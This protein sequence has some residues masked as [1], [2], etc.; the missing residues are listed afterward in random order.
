MPAPPLGSEP[1]IVRAIADIY[2]LNSLDN[3]LGLSPHI[4]NFRNVAYP[5]SPRDAFYVVRDL[6][7]NTNVI[8]VHRRNP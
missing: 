3:A 1:A 7:G 2:N 4:D 5:K 6:L 8:V